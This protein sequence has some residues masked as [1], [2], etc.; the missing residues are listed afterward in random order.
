M[1]RQH[2]LVIAALLMVAAAGTYQ[3]TAAPEVVT[4]TQAPVYEIGQ[5]VCSQGTRG[6]VVRV[7]EMQHTA[8]LYDVDYNGT[9]IAAS[10]SD[11]GTCGDP[12]NFDD[13]I[14]AVKARNAWLFTV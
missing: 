10:E 7:Y 2:I 9:T 5:P 11:L 3:F 14:K 1:N 6:K 4:V 12:I 13:Y 8:N